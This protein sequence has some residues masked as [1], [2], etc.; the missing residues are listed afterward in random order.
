MKKR[1]FEKVDFYSESW[2]IVLNKLENDGFY[3]AK[4]N[5][6]D[7]N[8][9]TTYQVA[10]KFGDVLEDLGYINLSTFPY[11]NIFIDFKKSRFILFG[12]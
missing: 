1:N 2:P 3:F 8:F 5:W 11:S 7:F 10:V 4:D 6:D 9:K 12:F